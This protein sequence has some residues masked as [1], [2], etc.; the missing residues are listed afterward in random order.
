[1]PLTSA[2]QARTDLVARLQAR[3][4]EIE[5]EVLTR[6]YAISDPTQRADPSYAEGLR[7]AVSAAVDY[8][9]AGIEHGEAHTSSV[10]SALL[11]QAR[12]AAQNRVSLDTVLRRYLAG[13]TVLGDFLVQEVAED[14]LLGDSE[15]K[16][17]L[18]AQA[19]LLDRLLADVSDEYTKATDRQSTPTAEERRAERVERLLAGEMLETSELN[20]DF[21]PWHIGMVI[22]DPESKAPIR[23]LPTLFNRRMLTIH[24]GEGTVWVWLA[25]RRRID[26]IELVRVLSSEWPEGT[27]VAI[28]E[29]GEGLSGWRLTHR[30]AGAAMPLA[31]RMGKSVVRYADVA[32]LASTL[33]DDLLTTSLHS[34]YLSPLSNERNGGFT[35]RET[36]RAYFAAERKVSSAAAS[37]GVTRR[38]VFNRLRLVEERL[39]S[40]LSE[41]AIQIEVALSLE[42]LGNSIPK[43]EAA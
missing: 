18:R 9:L 1:M 4:G 36:L 43:R 39:N 12:L 13:Y 37:L 31:H 19:A 11:A 42:E 24:R 29:P 16:L 8:G 41:C 2:V 22:S 32:L 20:Y 35:L 26:P 34:L 40:P 5:Q 38:T 10:P 23:E 27:F 25:G 6:V 15:L 17:L 7:A 3:R 30:Q 21:D 14:R 28:G 33:H